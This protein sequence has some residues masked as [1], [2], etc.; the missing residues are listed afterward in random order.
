VTVASPPDAAWLWLA[1]TL[2]VAAVVAVELVPLPEQ[3]A[4]RTAT[5]TSSVSG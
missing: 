2:A 3:P 1:A 5:P 4:R